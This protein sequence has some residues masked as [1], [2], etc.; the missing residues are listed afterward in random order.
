MKRLESID[1]CRAVGALGVLMY[2]SVF[3]HLQERAWQTGGLFLYLV[4]LGCEGSRGVNLF[5]VVSGFCIHA[6]SAARNPDENPGFAAFWM[7]RLKRLYPPYLAALVLSVVAL[8]LVG[9]VQ[10]ALVGTHLQGS[11]TYRTLPADASLGQIVMALLTHLLLLLP[12]WPHSQDIVRNGPFWTLALEEQLYLLY[13]LVPW[14]RRRI[15]MEQTVLVSLMVSLLYACWARPEVLHAGVEAWRLAPARW[16]EWCLG[17]WAVEI[18]LGK[19]RRPGWVARP[20]VGLGVLALAVLVDFGWVRGMVFQVAMEPLWGLG[21]FVLLNWLVEQ[22]AA[23]RWAQRKAMAMLAFVGIFSY[24]L[25]LVHEPLLHVITPLA[26][27]V[28]PP[29]VALPLCGLVC[30]PLAWLFFRRVEQ[31]A[32]AWSRAAR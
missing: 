16:F 23:G 8:G 12:F 13:F 7:R 28:W 27:I 26:Y 15:G 2:H 14:L 22:E 17:A 31:P 24:S 32:L 1:V 19:S 9:M 20:A 6:R 11:I 30:I 5:L 25:Y 3:G 18:H 10:V 4:I 29:A 21:F